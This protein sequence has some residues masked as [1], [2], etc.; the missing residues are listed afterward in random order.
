MNK[1]NSKLISN[2]LF[3]AVLTGV[4][5]LFMFPLIWMVVSSFKPETSI[6]R[7]LQSIKAFQLPALSKD[8]FQNYIEVL[9]RLP[10]I[11]AEFKSRRPSGLRKTKHS[12]NSLAHRTTWLRSDLFLHLNQKHLS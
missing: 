3:L 1:K 7:D 9:H 10:I 11:K 2:I 8:Y 12:T 6:M 5:L 4:A